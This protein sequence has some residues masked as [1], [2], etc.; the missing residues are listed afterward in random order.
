MQINSDSVNET[1]LK[2]ILDVIGQLKKFEI[3]ASFDFDFKVGEHCPQHNKS[4]RRLEVLKIYWHPISYDIDK[5]NLPYF[6][7]LKHLELR[8]NEEFERE[9]GLEHFPNI[10]RLYLWGTTLYK[11]FLTELPKLTRLR[12]LSLDFDET[13]QQDLEAMFSMLAE[14]NSLDGLNVRMGYAIDS[15]NFI[16]K[17]CKMTNLKRLRLS[18]DSSF[19]GHLLRIAENLQNL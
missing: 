19:N 5:H 14:T 2:K 17:L 13:F 9:I 15:T 18:L 4:D 11:E 1:E 6:A 3:K 16:E 7:H 10:E 12:K 8:L